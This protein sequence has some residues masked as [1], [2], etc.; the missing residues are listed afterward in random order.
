MNQRLTKVIDE[1]EKIKRK[2][3]DYQTRLRDLE[4]QKTELENADIVALV[5]GTDIHPDKFAEFVRMF[6]E[7]E[8]C[9]IPDIPN[10]SDICYKSGISDANA[11]GAD[12]LNGNT[13]PHNE[14]DKEDSH[15]EN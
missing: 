6:K 4:R 8:N 9:A 1:I 12:T 10:E 3:A 14:K 11:T 5:R 2:L 15:I 7:R 13:D